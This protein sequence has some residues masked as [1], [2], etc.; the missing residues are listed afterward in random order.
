MARAT[1]IITAL[2]VLI[3]LLILNDGWFTIDAR[4]RGVLLRT[5]SVI[6]VAEPG[7]H[8][9]L[10]LVDS[11]VRISTQ[12]QKRRYEDLSSYSRDVQEAL[13]TVSVNFQILPGAVDKVYER[14]GADII[15]RIID[16][17]VPDRL[18]KVF[19]G[20]QATT[21]I[22][23]RARLGAEVEKAIQSAMPT[24]VVRVLSV[25]IENITFSST[26]E[27]AI[28]A[29]ARAEAAVRQ[30]RNELERQKIEA[31]KVVVD[32]KGQAD[33]VRE[34]AQASADAI[35]LKGEAEALAIKAKGDALRN[36]PGL[37]T[38]IAAERWN[39]VLPTT[40]VPGAAVPFL[41]IPIGSGPTGQK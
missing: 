28:E 30:S 40:Q 15:D 1:A 22:A 11:I 33:A 36:N 39:G 10:P 16:P 18:K 20:Y 25:Q 32:A 31:E 8:F 26:Y 27:A 3:G 21:V 4:E 5:G 23:E 35:R 19:G 34:A 24:D 13:I 41:E 17:I 9:K 29:A 12:E 37:V 14:Y 2:V 6:G 38:L 7:F